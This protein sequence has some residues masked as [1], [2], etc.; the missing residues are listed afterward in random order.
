MPCRLPIHWS[1]FF[2]RSG[3]RPSGER[4]GLPPRH[5]NNVMSVAKEVNAIGFVDVSQLPSTNRSVKLLKI[6]L[7]DK[8][9]AVSA[10]DRTSEDYPLARSY[11]LYE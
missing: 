1:R 5:G 11:A 9:F 2:G 8:Q 4:R 3:A 10:R 7:P 6:L